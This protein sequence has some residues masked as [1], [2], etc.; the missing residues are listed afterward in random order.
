[1]TVALWLEPGPYQVLVRVPWGAADNPSVT[2]EA[3]VTLL[4]QSPSYWFDVLWFPQNP[5]LGPPAIAGPGW[6]HC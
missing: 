3:V 2:A 1:M 5:T 4:T 6:R